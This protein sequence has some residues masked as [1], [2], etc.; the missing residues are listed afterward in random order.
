MVLG[1]SGTG[2]ELVAKAIHHHSRRA[3]G[4][5]IT[6]NSG[7]MPTALLESNPFGHVR[8]AFTGAVASKKRLFEMA[9]GGSVFFDESGNIPLDTQAKLL[10]GKHSPAEELLR[11]VGGGPPVVRSGGNLAPRRGGAPGGGI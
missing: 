11:A 10:Q 6:V 4:P 9:D 1:E 5:F 8:G 3:G 7:S 2:K